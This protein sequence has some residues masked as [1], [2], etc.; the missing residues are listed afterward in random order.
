MARAEAEREAPRHDALMA[1]MDVDAAGN[2]RAR[3][4]SKLARVQNSLDAT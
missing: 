3:V 1:R 2:A 4:E